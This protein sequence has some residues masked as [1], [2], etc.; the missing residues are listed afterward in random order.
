MRTRFTCKSPA[1]SK[2]HLVPSV[3]LKRISLPLNIVPQIES[4][5]FNAQRTRGE[6]RLRLNYVRR[7]CFQ[8][9]T[10]HCLYNPN[11]SGKVKY[12]LNETQFLRGDVHGI[13]DEPRTHLRASAYQDPQHASARV[14]RLLLY[15]QPTQP[16]LR[17]SPSGH[18]CGLLPYRPWCGA[19]GEVGEEAQHAE[20]RDVF[21]ARY[22]G[23][24][25][26]QRER[27]LV[28]GVA[29]IVVLRSLLTR[30]RWYRYVVVAAVT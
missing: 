27:R 3:C 19:G 28:V 6:A 18:C 9:F 2:N 30:P 12:E 7:A 1:R 16:V 22:A 26:E 20:A 23:E 10:R 5:K 24:Q 21:E 13:A 17:P 25:H 8:L 29:H 4:T 15:A 14:I 11:V